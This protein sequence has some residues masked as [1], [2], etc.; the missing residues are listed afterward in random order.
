MIARQFLDLV[1]GGMVAIAVWSIVGAVI[2]L[3]FNYPDAAWKFVASA[4]GS[5]LTL[6][7]V[8]IVERRSDG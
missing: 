8:S 3:G 6:I 1:G 4:V 5:G 7:A 2:A